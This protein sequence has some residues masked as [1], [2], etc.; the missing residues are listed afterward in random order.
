[1]L[2]RR[3]FYSILILS[4][5]HGR[6]GCRANFRTIAP[7]IMVINPAMQENPLFQIRFEI[8]FDQ[9]RAGHVEPGV[10]ELLKRSQANID[11]IVNDDKPRTYGN[12]M[13]AL[14]QATDTLDY[15]P[16]SY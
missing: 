1:M 4:W 9:I 7:T 13:L 16:V 10:R 12:T 15:A 8:P 5:L 6:T 2:R 14:E 11:A 3:G